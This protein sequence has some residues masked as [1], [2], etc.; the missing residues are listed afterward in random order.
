MN[1]ELTKL[2]Y[3]NEKLIY[4]FMKDYN[5]Y[6][7][8]DDLYQV[9]VIG[10]INAYNNFKKEKGVKFSTYAYMY[11]QGEIKKFLR[12][13]RT[14]KINKDTNK[15]CNSIKK[16]KNILEQK[17]MKEPSTKELAEFLELPEKDIELALG[18]EQPV[19]S[20]DK[21]IISSNKEVILYDII[22][23]KEKISNLDRISLK[24]EL[25]KLNYI[26]KRILQE[27]YYNGRTQSEVASIL[28]MS[29]VKVSR[30]EK[31]VLAKLRSNMVA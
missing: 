28:G 1:E 14:F 20:S 9:G 12:E 30:E 5:K 16:A 25:S 27:R 13:N 6:I 18:I 3:D 10:L 23:S 24:E 21:P 19:Q 7:D 31:K 2:I 17:L 22:P 4:S 26:D 11:I 15:L 8:K 29:Q